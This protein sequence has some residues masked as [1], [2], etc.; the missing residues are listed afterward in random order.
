[1]LE[2]YGR[3]I[4]RK[5]W[6]VIGIVIMVT[7]GFSTL[8]PYLEMET[9]TEDFMPDNEV[10]TASQKISEYF[11][12]TGEM[13]MALV[14]KENAQNILIPTALKEQYHLVKNMEKYGEVDYIVSI[15]TFIDTICQLEFGKTLINCSDEIGRASCRERV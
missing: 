9:S 11:G 8:I 5:P 14:E 10:V 3:L 1:M 6:F 13:L 15:A 12:Q 4:E 7:I 2:R